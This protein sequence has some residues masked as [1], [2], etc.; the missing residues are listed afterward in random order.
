ML[1]TYLLSL[2]IILVGF[3]AYPLISKKYIGGIGYKKFIPVFLGFT[4]LGTLIIP[5][6]VYRSFTFNLGYVPL[7][8]LL[9]AMYTVAIYLVLYSIENYHVSIINTLVGAQQVLIALFSSVFFF[10]FELKSILFPF[11][12]IM[13]GTAFLLLNAEGRARFSKYVIFA[14]IAVLIWVFMWVIFYTI[15]TSFPLIYYAVLQSF[16]FAFCL[17]VAFLQNRHKSIKY[18]VSGEKF[19]YIAFAGVLNGVATVVFS[20]AYKYNALL[21]PFIAQLAIPIV[22]VVS[23][24]FFRERPKK[25]SL[26]GIILITIGSFVYI[27]V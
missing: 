25:F 17:P 4:A 10:I 3:S 19:H 18:Y 23:F 1:Y 20:F 21:T 5:F 24:L 14:L 9:G 12:I 7:L 2:F 8:A 6:I 26:I 27:F 16:S 15:N 13:A 22:I 11:L